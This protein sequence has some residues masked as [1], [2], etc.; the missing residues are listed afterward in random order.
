[1]TKR[2]DKLERQNYKACAQSV[3][4]QWRTGCNAMR[5]PIE[6]AGEQNSAPEGP[7]AQRLEQSTH[8]ALVGGSN[9]SGPTNELRIM[10]LTMRTGW[11]VRLCVV[12]I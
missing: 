1:M 2:L 5:Y 9:P 6:W 3:W 11:S 7:V 10:E 12:P 4:L 8:N